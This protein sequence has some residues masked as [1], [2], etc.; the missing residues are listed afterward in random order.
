MRGQ[1][2]SSA[3]ISTRPALVS[4][5]FSASTSRNLPEQ[6]GIAGG[7]RSATSS[8]VL[9]QAAQLSGTAEEA[10]HDSFCEHFT[11]V[12]DQGRLRDRIVQVMDADPAS[13][14]PRIDEETFEEMKFAE[15]VPPEPLSIM[16]LERFSCRTAWHTVREQR[17]VVSTSHD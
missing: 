4:V 7:Y 1:N 12:S 3:P 8:R 13:V 2:R 15:C 9:Q 6:V 5:P 10:R 17:L 14:V 11:D 16:G